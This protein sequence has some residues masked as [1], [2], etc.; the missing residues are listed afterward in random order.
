MRT[1]SWQW[2]SL[3]I[4]VVTIDCHWF[5]H[6]S[7]V[8]RKVDGTVAISAG[9]S[10]Q[11]RPAHMGDGVSDG[12]VV[13]TGDESHARLEFD[14]GNLVD[15]EANT[16]LVVRPKGG[17]A[18]QFGAV[19]LSGS[20]HAVSGV[21]G[22][23]LTIG[24]P[25][26]MA[27]LGGKNAAFAVDSKGLSVLV[28]T[29]TVQVGSN[30]K[31]VQ[32]GQTLSID[33]LVVAVGAAQKT[34]TLSPMTFMLVA[35]P[36]Q[37]QVRRA[38]DTKWKAV[39]KQDVLNEGDAVRT[40]AAKDTKLAV[41]NNG[42][43]ALAHDT[44]MVV[45]RAEGTTDGQQ[46]ASYDMQVGEASIHLVGTPDAP[47]SHEVDV[48]GKRVKIETSAH[49]ADVDVR[50]AKDGDTRVVV[51]EGRVTLADG[52]IVKAGQAVNVK[53]G[54]TGTVAPLADT[55]VQLKAD[56][57][58]AIYFD[59]EIPAVNFTWAKS[60]TAKT[61]R[62]ELARDREFSKILVAEDVDR[63]S[64]VYDHIETGRFYWRVHQGDAS[65][66]GTVLVDRESAQGDCPKCKRV[67]VIDDTG[68][69]TVVYFQKTV[70]ALTL[71]W[72]PNSTAASFKVK[73]FVDGSF[74]DPLITQDTKE[75]Q[76]ELERG[77]LGEGKYYWLVSARD[78]AGAELKAGRM[79]SL[80]I[81]YDN[82]IVDFGL[83]EPTPNEKTHAE[84]LVSRGEVQL[85][86]KLFVNG[87][88]AEVD[89][90]GRFRER[91]DLHKG[92]NEIVYHTI[93]TDGLDRFYVRH[94]T[95][96]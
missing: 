28:G 96:H 38:G 47:A 18:T 81:A 40:R 59:Q 63:N 35:N 87:K 3:A 20:L 9:E 73:V 75:V 95:R 52:T 82:A 36:L 66:K 5:K 85:G 25:F 80:E 27:D 34:V 39:K 23:H 7:A 37:V 70:P 21:K 4:V 92:D 46:H 91:V 89:E 45:G 29:V 19:L 51:H 17:A 31:T 44:E 26:G 83:R 10:T 43:V 78:A 76:I 77:R 94:V 42:Q 24:T 71:R 30:L 67:N 61:A 15:I 22:L 54:V 1:R 69:Q 41:A 14:G 50:A 84:S 79:N 93:G 65:Q 12:D 74:D 57:S 86:A 88:R 72:P 16:S 13:V 49:D 48:A 6:P 90:K 60:A 64:F 8:F 68:E 62:F 58:A 32:A 33:G 55:Q 2:L 53:N 56:T 11:K